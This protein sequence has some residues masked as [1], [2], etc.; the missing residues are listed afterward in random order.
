MEWCVKQ[1]TP[2]PIPPT[3][4][5]WVMLQWPMYSPYG[6]LRRKDGVVR[7]TNYPPHP[8]NTAAVGDVAVA[9]VLTVRR[10]EEEGRSGV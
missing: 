7:K 4:R 6:G 8:T 3:L 1:T 9:D 2:P 5:P 10:I